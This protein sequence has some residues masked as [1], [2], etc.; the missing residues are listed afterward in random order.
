MK[1]TWVAPL[2]PLHFVS[3]RRYRFNPDLCWQGCARHGWG[4]HDDPSFA[5]VWEVSEAPDAWRFTRTTDGAVTTYCLPVEETRDRVLL[6]S[7][8]LV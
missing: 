1:I 8:E 4:W 3:G 5:G 6:E 2:R 7:Y